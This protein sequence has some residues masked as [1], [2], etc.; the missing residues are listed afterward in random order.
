[1]KGADSESREDAKWLRV[2]EAE[3]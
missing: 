2:V 1:M 3:A